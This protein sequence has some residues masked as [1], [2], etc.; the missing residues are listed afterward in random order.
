MANRLFVSVRLGEDSQ[1]GNPDS[2]SQQAERDPIQRD[3]IVGGVGGGV[4]GRGGLPA[5][6][7]VGLPSLVRKNKRELELGFKVFFPAHS[8]SKTPPSQ[9]MNSR[10]LG[11]RG[12]YLVPWEPPLHKGNRTDDESSS[13]TPKTAAKQLGICRPGSLTR[14]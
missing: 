14:D 5:R 9:S 1:T 11:K 12:P 13:P 2:T 10:T 8:H 7:T 3:L 6:E 4:E